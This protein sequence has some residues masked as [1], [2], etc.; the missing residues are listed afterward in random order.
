MPLRSQDLPSDHAHLTE[1]VLALNAE[2]E[3]LRATV[4]T[5]KDMIFG[6]RSEKGA[7]IC[8]EQLP[9]DFSDIEALAAPPEPAND[10]REDEAC[11]PQGRE[12]R[13]RNIGALPKH[14]AVLG[15]SFLAAGKPG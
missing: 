7:V 12:K 15:W 5:L 9:L 10:D 8:A 13:H 1:M 4:R 2:V 6:A 11:A 3:T 14:R